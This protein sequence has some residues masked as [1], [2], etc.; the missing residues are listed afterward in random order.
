VGRVSP[1]QAL[2][3][4]IVS[5]TAR[6]VHREMESEGTCKQICGPANRNRNGGVFTWARGPLNSKPDTIRKV[7]AIH[8][9]AGLREE[10]PWTFVGAAASRC[11][12]HHSCSRIWRFRCRGLSEVQF[13]TSLKSVA[14]GQRPQFC[15]GTSGYRCKTLPRTFFLVSQERFQHNHET[16]TWAILSTPRPRTR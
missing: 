14:P 3:V 1:L 8:E 12:G 9:S 7:K 6:G 4:G 16:S 15:I 11:T 10:W 5:R 13:R 2:M